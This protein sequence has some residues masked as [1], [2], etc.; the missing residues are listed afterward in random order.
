[1]LV[2]TFK[3]TTTIPVEAECIT[4]DHLAAKRNFETERLAAWFG[5]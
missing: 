5:R 3:S 4:P 2:L 1:M